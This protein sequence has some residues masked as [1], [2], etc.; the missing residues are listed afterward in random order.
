MPTR[1]TSV[2]G[3]RLPDSLWA[4]VDTDAKVMGL[5]RNAYVALRIRAAKRRAAEVED[6][7]EMVGNSDELPPL[8]D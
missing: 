8:R 6:S 3:I 7:D 5:S 2:K 1:G 4:W